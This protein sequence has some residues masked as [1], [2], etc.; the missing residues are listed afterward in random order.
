MNEYSARDSSL[1]K[2]VSRPSWASA[3]IV[4]IAETIASGRETA[5]GSRAKTRRERRSHPVSPAT[6]TA[7]SQA[8]GRDARSPIAPANANIAQQAATAMAAELRSDLMGEPYDT[9]Y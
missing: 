7:T 9:L 5:D 1:M 2:T 6:A 3:A 4:A 8:T